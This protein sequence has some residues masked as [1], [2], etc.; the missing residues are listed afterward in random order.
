[1]FPELLEVLRCPTCE[2][3][4]ALVPGAVCVGDE[5]VSGALW[6]AGCRRRFP[7]TE[8]VPDMLGPL[9]PATPAQLANSLPITAWAYERLWRWYA[10]SVLSGERFGWNREL[11]L[12][13]GL[14]AP[15]RP[16]LYLDVACSN[17]LYARALAQARGTASGQVVGIDHALPMLHEARRC[18]RRAGLRISYVRAS[19]QRLPFAAGAASGVAMGGSLNEIGDTDAALSAMRRSLAANGRCVLMSLVQATSLAGRGLQV[20][21]SPGGVRFLPLAEHNRR[22]TEAGLRIVAQWQHRVVVF[23]LCLPAD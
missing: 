8:G 23:T 1:M 16:G 21:L 17:G 12:V 20:A 19:A 15:E 14:M 13:A 10:L 2:S 3:P 7:I 11:P 18:A 5:I 4:L 9:L 6:C 22:V